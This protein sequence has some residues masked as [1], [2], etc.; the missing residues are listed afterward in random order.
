MKNN[1]TLNIF[2]RYT[3]NLL[4]KSEPNMKNKSNRVLKCLL[5]ELT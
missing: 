1:L 5:K 3:T 4:D 2:W